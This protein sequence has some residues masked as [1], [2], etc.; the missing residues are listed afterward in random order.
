MS[1]HLHLF[2]LQPQAAAFAHPIL[3]I[4]LVLIGCSSSQGWVSWIRSW[5]FPIC[6]ELV[7]WQ[8]LGP[9]RDKCFTCRRALPHFISLFTA[10]YQAVMVNLGHSH[11]EGG[12]WMSRQDI[13]HLELFL[14]SSMEESA[15]WFR[16]KSCYLDLIALEIFVFGTNPSNM[17]FQ[18]V[19]LSFLVLSRL[20]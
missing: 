16:H 4:P 17:Y 3:F 14:T 19:I 8:Q 2:T 12:K 7:Q 18:T 20:C 5:G 9:C 11:G 1:S 6:S 13:F 10:L 15:G